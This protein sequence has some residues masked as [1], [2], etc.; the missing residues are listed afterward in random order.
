ML[1]STA[2][3]AKQ[4]RAFTAKEVQGVINM[5][6]SSKSMNPDGINILML[7]HLGSSAAKFLTKVLNLSK[8]ILRI[9]Y[10]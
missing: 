8:A 10:L 3:N 5:T 2:Q 9:P 4:L 7:K 1:P 6:K